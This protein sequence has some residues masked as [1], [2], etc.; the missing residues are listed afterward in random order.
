MIKAIELGGTLFLPATHKDIKCVVSGEKYPD[1]KSVLID[2]EDSLDDLESGLEAIQ[3]LLQT[4]KK[5]TLLVF[6]RPRNMEVLQ[7]ILKFQNIHLIEGFILPKFSLDNA[8][9]YLYILANTSYTIMPSIEGSELFEQPKLVELRDILLIHKEKIPL[10]RFGLE[11]ML[12]Q[13]K[14]RR[15]CQESIFDFTVTSSVLGNF[16]GIFKSAGF[17]VSAG[18]YPCFKDK[19][20]FINDVKRDLK[21]GLISKTIIHPNQ[22]EIINSLYKVNKKDYEEASEVCQNDALV[23][24]QNSK[25]AE[26]KTMFAY[27]YALLQ[28]AKIYGIKD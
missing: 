27:S 4:Y 18:V 28:R 25:M 17:D 26:T 2:T 15:T 6:I 11:D 16:I 14:M 10:V 12:R 3:T 1:L 22:I 8:R 23:F 21:E 24:N 20:G 5:S 19:E 7:E 13:L 9:K